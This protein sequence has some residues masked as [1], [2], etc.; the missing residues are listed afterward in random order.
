MNWK[1]KI[2]QKL[3]WLTTRFGSYFS[4]QSQ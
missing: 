3:H 1:G 2:L 4:I